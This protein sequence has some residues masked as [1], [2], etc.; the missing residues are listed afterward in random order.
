MDKISHVGSYVSL[1]SRG[2]DY[3]SQFY[4]PNTRKYEN[5]HIGE[6]ED[7]FKKY[8][9]RQVEFYK[10][11]RLLLPKSIHI[12]KNNKFKLEFHIKLQNK[13]KAIYI[14]SFDSL[15]EALYER[16]QLI[17]KIIQ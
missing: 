4:N 14:G 10:E 16:G 15:Q 5:L 12:N 7:C 13:S 1:T 11:N 6:R 3:F 9:E 2:D 8:C 17:L